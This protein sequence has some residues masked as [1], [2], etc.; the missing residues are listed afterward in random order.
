M[1]STVCYIVMANMTVLNCVPVVVPV[2]YT[3]MPLVTKIPFV[4]FLAGMGGFKVV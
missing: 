2:L 4:L 3:L 1:C